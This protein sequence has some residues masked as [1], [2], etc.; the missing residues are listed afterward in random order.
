MVAF[1]IEPA[2][3]IP[4][5]I[6]VIVAITELKE[7]PIWINWLPLFPSPPSLFSIGFTTVFSKHIEKPAMNAPIRY[8]ANAISGLECPD[9]N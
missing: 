8:T 5:N 9:K 2:M 1:S 3:R 7:P 6:G 4:T